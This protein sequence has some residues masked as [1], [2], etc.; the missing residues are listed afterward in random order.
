MPQLEDAEQRED[1]DAADRGRADEIGHDHETAAVV[2]V[3]KDTADEQ[4]DHHRQCP[5]DPHDR[6]GG[7][8]IADLVD[9][10]RQGD[11]EEAIAEQ[12]DGGAGREEGEVA[13]RQ[14]RSIRTRRARAMS[15][16]MGGGRWWAILDSNQ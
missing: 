6:E 5:R 3:R 10:P 11:V 9:L 13:V 14:G 4:E 12:R 16:V 15:E 2:S 1:P 7:R 8:D